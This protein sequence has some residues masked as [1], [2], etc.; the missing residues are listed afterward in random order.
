MNKIIQIN[1]SL[2]FLILVISQPSIAQDD[3]PV[4]ELTLKDSL[5]VL[6]SFDIGAERFQEELKAYSTTALSSLIDSIHSLPIPEQRKFTAKTFME[7]INEQGLPNQEEIGTGRA[8][9]ALCVLTLHSADAEFMK[10]QLPELKLMFAGQ[11]TAVIED[12]ICVLEDSPQIFGSQALYS[13]KENR[14]VFY[15]LID[16]INVDKRRKEVGLAPLESYAKQ[17]GIDWQK[18]KDYI[19]KSQ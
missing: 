9:E 5:V 13:T 4:S 7:I 17:I 16:P 12:K 6:L 1:L 10:T 8:L 15:K 18:E 2:L 11:S 3:V 19:L 14:T